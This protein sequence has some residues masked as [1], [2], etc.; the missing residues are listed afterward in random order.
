MSPFSYKLSDSLRVLH[1]IYSALRFK[2][3]TPLQMLNKRSVH[4]HFLIRK[5]WQFSKRDFLNN[6]NNNN[7]NESI[8]S[9]F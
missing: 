9:F 5:Q 2:T 1:M 7:K 8:L 4:F 6:N 3:S